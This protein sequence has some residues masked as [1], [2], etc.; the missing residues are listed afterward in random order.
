MRRIF[1]AQHTN[2]RSLAGSRVMNHISPPAS[3][4]S[5]RG[6]S[7]T[8]RRAAAPTRLFS[9]PATSTRGVIGLDLGVEFHAAT[10]FLGV[11][12]RIA[13]PLKLLHGFF[14]IFGTADRHGPLRFLGRICSTGTARKSCNIFRL[15]FRIRWVAFGQNH[16]N[17]PPY[18]HIIE[19]IATL[20]DAV[21]ISSHP[22]AILNL[23][24]RIENKLFLDRTRKDSNFKRPHIYA[25]L[26]QIE[27]CWSSRI[28][29]HRWQ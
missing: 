4:G 19:K 25:T 15:V 8:S 27:K 3:R 28:P 7:V 13:E 14:E 17:F 9:T 24:E 22:A 23:H 26:F 10:P 20:S 21:K 16:R 1:M 29:D 6:P 11:I 2:M 12:R 5:R 18:I